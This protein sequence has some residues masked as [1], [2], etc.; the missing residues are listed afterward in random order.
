MH[1]A[2][3]LLRQKSTFPQLESQQDQARLLRRE[4][5]K[6]NF[7]EQFFSALIGR[8][9]GLT[10]RRKRLRKGKSKEKPRGKRRRKVEVESQKEVGGKPARR[11]K[12][13]GKG[14][15]R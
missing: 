9:S 13:E 6:K 1:G 11:T 5:K 2:L 10:Q 8:E 12:D 3:L 4:K 15:A 14:E 7:D